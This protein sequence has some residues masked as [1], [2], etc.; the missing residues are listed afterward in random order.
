M[1]QILHNPRCT[2][3][4]ETLKILEDSNE[5]IEVV[6][7]LK[8]TPSAEELG[9]IVE[10]LGIKPEGLLRK[11]EAIYKEKFKGQSLTDD[12]WL[13]AMVEYPKLIERPIVI[14]GNKAIIGRPPEKVLSLL[15]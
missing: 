12:Q 8:T 15:K 10:K 11:G 5:F 2:K 13:E 6:E 1:I 9:E 4:R 7:Y 3:S 14:K